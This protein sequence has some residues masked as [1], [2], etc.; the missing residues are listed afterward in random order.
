MRHGRIQAQITGKVKE[1]SATEA[2]R[3]TIMAS[4]RLVS[5]LERK[6]A[7]LKALLRE[8]SQDLR[9]AR[10]E[11]KLLTQPYDMEIGD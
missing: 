4:A 7:N 8:V 2:K 1:V 6:Q 3:R 5:R 11:F 10:K 9:F